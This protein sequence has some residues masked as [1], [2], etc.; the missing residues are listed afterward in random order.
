MG[1]GKEGCQL[2]MHM[3]SWKRSYTKHLSFT[4]SEAAYC[5][6]L[7]IILA[8]SRLEHEIT[9]TGNPA[10]DE[11]WEKENYTVMEREQALQELEEETARLVSTQLGKRLRSLHC[12]LPIEHTRPLQLS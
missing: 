1:L 4:T 8:S 3:E 5:G 11:E 12:G 2:K 6:S 7:W 10:E 9:Q